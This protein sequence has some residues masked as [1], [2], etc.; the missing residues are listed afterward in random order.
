MADPKLIAR[1][2]GR[3]P[4]TTVAMVFA[5]LVM[6]AAATMDI[7]VVDLDLSLLRQIEQSELDEIVTAWVLV[8]VAFGVDQVV[9]L[10]VIRREESLASERIRVV[11]V[12]MRTVQD[13]VGN[14]L[15]ELQLLRMEAEGKVPP[16]ALAVFDESIRTTTAKLE[17]I[18]ELKT[19]AETQMAV[20][21]GLHIGPSS[22]R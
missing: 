20:G 2:W 9:A 21:P 15:T 3:L 16:E 1:A 13:I 7:N 18:E 14:C 4:F 22:R 6:V 10:R 17:A 12:T 19:F 8:F 11:Q 5:V